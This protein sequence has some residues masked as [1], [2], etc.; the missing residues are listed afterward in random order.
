VH[1]LKALPRGSLWELESGPGLAWP[2]TCPTGVVN[3]KRKELLSSLPKILASSG[4]THG[5]NT[6]QTR[7]MTV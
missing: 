5:L 6:G 2:A 4:F 1:D 7:S 3:I